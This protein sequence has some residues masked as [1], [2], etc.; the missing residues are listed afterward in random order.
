MLCK[1]T[2]TDVVAL[3]GSYFRVENSTATGMFPGKLLCS[4]MENNLLECLQYD[5]THV[6]TSDEEAGVRCNG[7]SLYKLFS[8]DMYPAVH[9]TIY[10]YRC[11]IKEVYLY[12]EP[13]NSTK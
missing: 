9:F 2:P 10:E 7:K 5:G 11:L 4:G 12:A 1:Y 13:L 8:R 3:K 6:C